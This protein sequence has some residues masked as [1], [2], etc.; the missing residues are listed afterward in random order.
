MTPGCRGAPPTDAMSGPKAGRLSRMDA[1]ETLRLAQVRP[2]LRG[3]VLD[4]ACGYNNLLRDHPGG[5]GAD[6][7]PWPGIDVVAE[8]GALP[9]RA[10]S[11]DTVTVLAALN[12]F[13]DR[14]R[15]LREIHDVLK[16]DGQ[17]ILTMIGPLTGLV[18][19][20]LFRHDV[21]QRGEMAHEEKL[22]LTDREVRA[23][24]GATG[25]VLVRRWGFELGLNR[26]YVA[27]KA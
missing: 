7:H 8:A 1:V 6:V 16:P 2:L 21:H 22:G 20:L 17:L 27:V 26:V 9:F 12:H 13:A 11:F 24:L 15:A 14:P 23:L 19:H 10:G 4:V 3:R 25:Y 5:V 18:A